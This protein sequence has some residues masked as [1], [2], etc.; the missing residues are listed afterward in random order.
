MYAVYKR[1]PDPE[2][3]DKQ[4]YYSTL[5]TVSEVEMLYGEG[6]EL[7]TQRKYEKARKCFDKASKIYHED[8]AVGYKS[9]PLKKERK[10]QESKKYLDNV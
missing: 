5:F 10:Y 6:V 3:V 4:K 9:I 8:A 7:V 2:N 1:V